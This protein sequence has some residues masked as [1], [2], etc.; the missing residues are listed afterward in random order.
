MSCLEMAVANPTAVRYDGVART[1][2]VLLK[3]SRGFF[4]STVPKKPLRPWDAPRNEDSYR[5]FRVDTW[6]VDF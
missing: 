1:T 4:R 5:S 3:E 6:R 2:A